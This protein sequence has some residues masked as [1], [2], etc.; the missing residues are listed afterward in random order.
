MCVISYQLCRALPGHAVDF[1]EKFL[2]NFCET[3][4]TVKSCRCLS[5]YSLTVELEL[6]VWV[7]QPHRRL[8]IR[9]PEDHLQHVFIKIEVIRLISVNHYIH[10]QTSVFTVL[11]QM[12]IVCGFN[13]YKYFSFVFSQKCS[14]LFES[15]HINCIKD[16]IKS[17]SLFL[18][19]HFIIFWKKKISHLLTIYSAF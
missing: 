3:S 9:D 1:L 13:F 17:V 16:A 7:V 2:L 18:L 11:N 12:L 8:N 5:R 10:F 4:W 19:L 6:M 14:I 15:A